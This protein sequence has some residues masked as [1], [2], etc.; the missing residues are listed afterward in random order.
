MCYKVSI[1]PHK[2][3]QQRVFFLQ[4]T[5]LFGK[6]IFIIVAYFVKIENNNL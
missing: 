6:L 1:L 4:E 5:A 3:G 2:I